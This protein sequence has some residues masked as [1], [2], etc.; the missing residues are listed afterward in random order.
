MGQS[1]DGVISFGVTC[2]EDTEFPWDKGDCEED[3]VAW[4]R[5]L[6]G[7]KDIHHPWTPEGNFAEGWS[8]GDPRFAEYFAHRNQWLKAHPLPVHL[9]NYCSGDCPMYAIVAPGTVRRC[10]RGYPETFV[11]SDLSVTGAQRDDLLAFLRKHQIEHYGD[12][13]WLLTSYWG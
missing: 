13:R 11:P 6:Q 4:W 8:E 12:P 5:E 10:T 1:T 9:E 3:L 2:E 7:F